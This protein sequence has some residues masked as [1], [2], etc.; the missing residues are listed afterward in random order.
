MNFII[1]LTDPTLVIYLN[2]AINLKPDMKYLLTITNLHKDSYLELWCGQ[3]SK[4]F[5][6]DM[7]QH[8]HCNTSGINFGFYPADGFESDFNEFNSGLIADL[9]YSS[10][11]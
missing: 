11:S 1:N 3:V 5:L 9:I 10:L 4:F 2:K 7:K 6:K 8:I